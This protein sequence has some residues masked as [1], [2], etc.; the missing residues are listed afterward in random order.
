MPTALVLT[1]PAGEVE[2]ASDALWALGVLAIE[3]R[4]PEGAAAPD[5]TTDDLV[6]LWTSLGDD[7]ESVA[8][9]AGGFPSRWRWR[10]VEV[11]PAVADSWRA[12]AAPS[13]VA[14]DLVV[15]PAWIP[16]EPPAS[17]PPGLIVVRIEPGSTFGLGDHPTTVLSLRAMRAAMWRG[18]SVLDVGCG[19]GVLAVAAAVLGAASVEAIDV[20]P[21]AVEATT[22]NA[23]A[24]GVGHL[25]HA[26]TTPLAELDGTFDVVVANILAPTLIELAEDLRRVLD[27]GGLL[28]V[29]GLLADRTE[30]VVAALAPLVCVDRAVREGWTALTFRW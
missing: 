11:D 14:D 21:A 15:V 23:E 4:A 17:A 13:W 29:S 30:H 25:V 9:A 24:N 2:L 12:H 19:S 20:S 10:L 18:A 16:F 26:S 22:A 27:R 8:R 1:V 7:V 6:E 3:E 5:G 28:V